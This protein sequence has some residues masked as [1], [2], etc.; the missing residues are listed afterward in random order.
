MIDLMGP[1][2]T[3]HGIPP[4]AGKS[5]IAS[6]TLCET[7]VSQATGDDRSLQFSNVQLAPQAWRGHC[8][9]PL[10]QQIVAEA[11]KDALIETLM[12]ENGLLK[13]S[14]V[15]LEAWCI[16]LFV[17]AVMFFMCWRFKI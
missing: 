1:G 12:R 17:L 15:W 13:R 14:R 3:G 7:A 9:A 6:T 16:G 2:A 8:G 11:Q 10:G 5:E 4:F